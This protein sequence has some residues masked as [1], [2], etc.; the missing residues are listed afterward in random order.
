[1]CSIRSSK[2][3]AKTILRCNPKNKPDECPVNIFRSD[4]T[5]AQ[6]LYKIIRT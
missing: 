2:C 6:S 3:K 4:K 1:M 5:S